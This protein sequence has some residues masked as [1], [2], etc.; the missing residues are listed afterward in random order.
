MDTAK[1]IRV[2]LADDHPI[3][4]QGVNRQ[5]DKADDRDCRTLAL[6]DHA[7]QSRAKVRPT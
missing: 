5:L 6:R 4:R 3:V 1:T 2:L 7:I